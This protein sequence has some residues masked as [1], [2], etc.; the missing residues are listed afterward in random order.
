MYSFGARAD[1]AVSDEPFYA[2]YLKTTGLN[3]PMRDEILASQPNDAETVAQNCAGPTPENKSHWYQKHMCQ[4]MLEGFPTDWASDCKNVFL[5]RNP[6]RVIA[7][8][9]VKRQRPNLT[10]IG[11]VQQAALFDR[12]GGIVIDSA[13]IRTDP[14]GM[15]TKLCAA[16]DLSFDPAMLC[17]PLGGHAADG[18]WAKHWYGAVRRSTGFAGSEGPPPTLTGEMADLCVQA[19]P[20]YH[21]LKQ[22]AI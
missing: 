12:F 3:H 7:S 13:D 20:H 1:F 11:F 4:H 10:D 2:A 9:A 8:Y 14:R 18:V 17:W 21:H 15:I 22:H 19:L 5:I 16:L 6:A